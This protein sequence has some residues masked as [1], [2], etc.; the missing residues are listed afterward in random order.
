[1][2]KLLGIV[3]LC[4]LLI[5]PSQADDIK[6]FQIE[7]M[8]IGDSLLDYLTKDNIESNKAFY[9]GKKKYY[10]IQLNKTKPENFDIIFGVGETGDKKFI[11]HSLE[12]FINFNKNNF[13]ECFIKKKEIVT[14]VSKLFPYT[15]AEEKEYTHPYDKTKKS[16]VYRSKYRLNSG[17]IEITCFDMSKKTGQIDSL[18]LA[19]YTKKFNEWLTNEA[20]K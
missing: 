13:E 11:I 3:V 14:E 10:R 15:T 2:K 8:S 6:E 1:M 5:N 7:G 4:L 9:A 17:G 16:M 20:Y 19:I 18:A 12:A